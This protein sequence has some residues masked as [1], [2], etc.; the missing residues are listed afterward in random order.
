MAKVRA[1]ERELGELHQEL[2]KTFRG[3]L[4]SGE[5][6]SSD[7]N[8]IRQFLKDNNIEAVPVE[9]SPLF[10]LKADMPVFDEDGNQVCYQ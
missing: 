4:K 6:K 2:C 5:C 8:V 3:M 7:L 10:D 1:T 9:G